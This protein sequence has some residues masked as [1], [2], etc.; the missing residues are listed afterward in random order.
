M[1]KMVEEWDGNNYAEFYWQHKPMLPNNPPYISEEYKNQIKKQW[2]E[3]LTT[4]DDW[5]VL[6]NNIKQLTYDYV[7][8]DYTASF[9][10]DWLETNRRTIL[11][12]S[13]LY[14]HS[15]FVA[16]NSLKYR[17]SCENR[18]LQQL[19]EKDPNITVMLTARAADGFWKTS[20]KHYLDKA[21]NF[22][23]TDIRELKQTE[24]HKED[25]KHLSNRPLGVV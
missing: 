5:N 16:M 18:L 13:N 9:N 17:I 10:F 14:N 21:D 23:Y 20:N 8:I 24:W 12:L 1:K 7:L 11:N 22:V 25:W 15:P 2:E 6:W 19:K 3:F 4:V